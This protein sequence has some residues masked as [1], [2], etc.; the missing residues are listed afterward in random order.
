M[1]KAEKFIIFGQDADVIVSVF[2]N[3]LSWFVKTFF[4]IFLTHLLPRIAEEDLTALPSSSNQ[5]KCIA[6]G[7]P[8]GREQLRLIT[9]K[10]G[11]AT[12]GYNIDNPSPFIDVSSKLPSNTVVLRVHSFSINYADCCIRFVS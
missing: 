8:G 6:I 12:C 5:T 7:R 1:A 10:P 11:Y 3:I 2:S 4:P 9:L